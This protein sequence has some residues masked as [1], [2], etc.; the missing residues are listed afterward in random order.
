M[1]LS[2]EPKSAGWEQRVILNDG[3]PIPMIGM[4]TQ[5]GFGAGRVRRRI[6]RWRAPEYVA[7]GLEVGFR[8]VDTARLYKTE[9]SVMRGITRS[10]IER[11]EVFVV[12]KA[13]PGKDHPA[14]LDSSRS[15]VAESAAR[16]GGYVDLY[17]VHVP[18]PGWQET[19]R[20]LEEARDRGLVRSI[21]VSNFS[22][23]QLEELRSFAR[24]P[25]AANQI[26]LHP[27]IAA[28]QADTVRYCEEHGIRIIAFP[29]RPWQVG[30]GSAVD[31]VAKSSDRSRV[32]V[33]LRW[34]VD[35]GFAIIPLSTNE[36]HLRENFAVREFS[37]TPEQVEAI[38]AVGEA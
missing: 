29:R 19:W 5:Y 6:I 15:A 25:V 16:L 24:H 17:L 1:P 26:R 27:F 28:S 34:A 4:G 38:D 33:M 14:G 36:E 22:P 31:E 18:D 10:G 12:S 7:L 8:L 2:E 32:Q 35:R 23:E 13:W 21:G 11:A 3:T 37:L 20:A 30:M 9:A